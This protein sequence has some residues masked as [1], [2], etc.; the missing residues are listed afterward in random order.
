M[1]MP[2]EEVPP[3]GEMLVLYGDARR[4]DLPMAP[5][6]DELPAVEDDVTDADVEAYIN[7]AMPGR[8][9]DGSVMNRDTQPLLDAQNL[10]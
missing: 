4:F 2:L 6:N 9:D 5:V 7:R 8:G 10:N 3:T 1:G